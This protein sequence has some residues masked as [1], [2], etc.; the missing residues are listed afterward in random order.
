MAP[1]AM[2]PVAPI[3]ADTPPYFVFDGFAPEGGI[4]HGVF[5]RHGG[6][7]AAPFASLN[8]SL[9]IG[10]DAT[11][12]A[13]NRDRVLAALGRPRS[14]LVMAGLVHGTGVARVYRTGPGLCLEG[15]GRYVPGVDVLVSDDPDA[16]LLLGAADCAQVFLL[17]PRRRAVGLAHAG[18]R[19]SAARVLI[20][21]VEAMRRFFGSDPR[22]IR[23]AAGP[24]LGPCCARFSDPY[25]ELPG[26]CA[27][28]I[29]GDRVDLWA[30]HR[31]QL[32]EAGLAPSRIALAEVCTVCHRDTFFSH[33]GDGGRTGRF[34]A[35]IGLH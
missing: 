31:Q 6:V 19:G 33:R 13:T 16:T 27:P 11:A 8:V 7:S 32:L 17:D 24:S 10:D 18:W 21:A 3:D 1:P 22:D 25:N 29:V 23:A 12:V 2:R 14:G 26:W 9:S 4:R 20:G 5:T 34:A 35:A 15:G 28:F 30:M